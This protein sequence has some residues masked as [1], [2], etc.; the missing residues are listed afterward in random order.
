MAR[1]DVGSNSRAFDSVENHHAQ[2][3]SR[4]LAI[5]CLF[6]LLGFSTEQ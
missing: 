2:N 1:S 5:A 4:E 3:E 6:E